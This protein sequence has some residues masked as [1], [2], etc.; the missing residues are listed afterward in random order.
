V[1]T[2]RGEFSGFE[3]I[4]GFGAKADVLNQYNRVELP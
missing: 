1:A 4:G 3:R 2:V